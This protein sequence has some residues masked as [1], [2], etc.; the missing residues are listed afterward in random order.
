[1]NNYW[2][3]EMNRINDSIKKFFEKKYLLSS[4]FEVKT[5]STSTNHSGHVTFLLFPIYKEIKKGLETFSEDLKKHLQQEYGFIKSIE[6]ISGFLNITFTDKFLIKSLENFELNFTLKKKKKFLIEFSSPNTNKPLHLGHL[7]NIF[8]GQATK[9]L[10]EV[11]GHSVFSTCVVNDRGIHICKSMAAY[12]SFGKNENPNSTNTKGDFF[13]GKYY[14]L[15]DKIFKEQKAKLIQEGYSEKEAEENSE[16]MIHARKLLRDWENNVPEVKSLW[17]KM[18][19]WVYEGFE[20]TYKKINVV[21]DKIYYESETF[22]LG[23]EII[24]KELEKKIFAKKENGSIFINLE[25]EGL[26]E[27]IVLRADGT[28]VY[29]TQ[30]IGMAELRNQEWVADEYIYV[31]GNEQ[32]YHFKVLFTILEKMNKSYAKN[33]HHLSY[34][35]VELPT[36]K[37]KSREG[38]VIDADNLISETFEIVKN[39]SEKNVKKKHSEK[40]D[41]ELYKKI[42]IGSLRYQMLKVDP[43]KKILFN[44]EE[45]VDI[46]GNT[47]LFI[48]YAYARINSILNKCD[49]EN[50]IYEKFFE[51]IELNDDEREVI[52]EIKNFREGIFLAIK[53]L[54]VNEVANCLYVLSKSYSKFYSQ[55][56][57]LKSFLIKNTQDEKKETF[58]LYLSKVI[59][60]CIK[61]GLDTLCIEAPERM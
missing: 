26:G 41:N 45:S 25:K 44:P 17:K 13:V 9:K 3:K 49:H 32:D 7:R 43:T 16:I 56:S 33:M 6:I 10:L 12:I 11:A 22:D 34:G 46:C 15:F 42:S 28:S 58:R 14:V 20:E 5:T 57:I 60:E 50:F 35:M 19:S 52:L 38:T 40:N 59:S 48:Q 23:K 47:S 8:L 2:G 61:F 4:D 54:K 55:N 24:K 53:D 51:N 31:V 29:I 27:K 37:M 36:G 39:H 21:F 1:M 30:D 18:N